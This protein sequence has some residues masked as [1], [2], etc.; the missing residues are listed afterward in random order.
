MRKIFIPILLGLFLSGCS[1]LIEHSRQE[2]RELIYKKLTVG[3]PKSEINA[4]IGEPTKK[5]RES[6]GFYTL[7]IP[8]DRKG[9]AGLLAIL[10]IGTLGLSEIIATPVAAVTPDCEK[11]NI[12]LVFD[13]N[14]KVSAIYKEDTYK[15]LESQFEILLKEVDNLKA[16][17]NYMLLYYIPKTGWFFIDK[18][19]IDCRFKEKL[20]KGYVKRVPSLKDANEYKKS[21]ELKSMPVTLYSTF[22]FNSEDNQYKEISTFLYNE[23]GDVL[24]SLP[25]TDWREMYPDTYSSIMGSLLSNY[26][27]F[28]EL[29][30]FKEKEKPILKDFIIEL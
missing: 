15:E 9:D 8:R 5:D 16:N 23:E 19:H 18:S 3:T 26:C 14:E 22:I 24:Y 28:N 6:I 11:E 29:K 20:I 30:E 2:R 27:K 1:A 21:F 17:E 12:V 13:K 10:G 25:D 4:I 7:C